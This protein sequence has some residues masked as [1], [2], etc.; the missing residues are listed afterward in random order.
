MNL[1]NSITNIQIDNASLKSFSLS[2]SHN[3][4]IGR[5]LV[6]NDDGIFPLL[7]FNRFAT[8]LSEEKNELC[9]ITIEGFLKDYSYA[10][11]NGESHF[12]KL[13]VVTAL[14]MDGKKYE[15]TE[16]EKKSLEDIWKTAKKNNYQLLD[17]VDFEKFSHDENKKGV[18]N[19][20]YQ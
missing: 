9:R 5:A 3:V 6:K 14:T 7:F 16:T 1:L 20:C 10:D 12:V 17:V 4:I 19:E 11:Y 8:I 2:L 18:L 15:T 13:N